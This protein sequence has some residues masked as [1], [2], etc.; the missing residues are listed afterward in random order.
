MINGCNRL[1]HGL[2]LFG[3]LAVIIG[4]LSGC[5]LLRRS[6]DSDFKLEFMLTLHPDTLSYYQ[7]GEAV[8]VMTRLINITDEPKNIQNINARTLSFWLGHETSDM[9]QKVE[10]VVSSN[11]PMGEF[12]EI[13]PYDYIE[14]PFV[15][16]KVTETT[17]TFT[18]SA[19]HDGIMQMGENMPPQP[20]QAI[21]RRIPLDVKGERILWR[22]RDGLLLKSD[23]VRLVQEKVGQPLSN[24]STTLVIDEMGFLAWWVTYSTGSP[25]RKEVRE[26]YL[27]N[28]Y[29]GV[30]RSK[31]QPFTEKKTQEKQ[32]PPLPFKPFQRYGTLERKSE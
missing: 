5:A 21:S 7:P 12:V 22:D 16:T 8:I 17:G 4:M 28:P 10:P 6:P 25:D 31:V 26:A 29:L 9:I 19:I 30:L 14:R 1:R 20:V 2:F 15:F 11:E 18:L 27:V 13:P 3:F 24:V 32:Q 23:A